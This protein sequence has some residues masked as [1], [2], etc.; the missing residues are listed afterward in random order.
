MHYLGL[1]IS[2]DTVDTYSDAFGHLKIENTIQGIQTLLAHLQ[3]NG[4]GKENTHVCC[5]ATNVYYLLVTTTLHQNGYAVSVVNPLAIKGY[6]KMQLKRIKTDKQDAKLIAEFAKKEKP[7]QWKPNNETSK[8]IQSLHRRTEQLNSLLVA[9]KNRQE[10]A[11]EYIKASVEKMIGILE[12]EL[13]SIREQIQAIIESDEQLKAKQKIL[14]TIPGVGKNTAQILLS[15]LV[16]LD[17]FRTAKH[18][19]SYLGLSPIIRDSGKYKGAQKVSKMGDK[20]LRKSLYMPARAAC[21]RSKLWRSWFDAQVAR[22]KHPKQ[23]YVMMMC[24]ILRYAYTCLKT[25]APFDATM[26]QKADKSER[27]WK[28]VKGEAL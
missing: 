6:V 15:V 13:Q 4:L 2:K 26:H 12:D 5:E 16:D 3:A 11:D 14:S 9:E 22:G 19:I 20:I 23:V 17:K 7:Q 21:T 25:N 1:D 27:S 18:L 8:A 28:T 24:K 10:T